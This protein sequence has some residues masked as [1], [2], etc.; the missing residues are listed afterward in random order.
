MPPMSL[1]MA[2]MSCV[3]QTEGL[4]HS[5]LAL[6]EVNRVPSF[7]KASLNHLFMQGGPQCKGVVGLRFDIVIVCHIPIALHDACT[8]WA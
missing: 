2:A 8:V 1:C 3:R 7:S 5:R 6:W 4:D